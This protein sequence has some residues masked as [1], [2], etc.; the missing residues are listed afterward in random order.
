MAVFEDK[1]TNTTHNK[2]ALIALPPKGTFNDRFVLT[3]AIKTLESTRTLG[4]EDYEEA[5]SDY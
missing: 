3:Y 2:M 5:S 1:L 4:T